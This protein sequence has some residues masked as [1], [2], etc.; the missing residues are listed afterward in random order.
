MSIEQI[1]QLEEI[2]EEQQRY[3]S[4]LEETVASYQQLEKIYKQWVQK[5][6]EMIDR[7]YRRIEIH[8]ST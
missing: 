5:Q 2:I 3:I 7:M 8:T 4:S 1:E 6:E